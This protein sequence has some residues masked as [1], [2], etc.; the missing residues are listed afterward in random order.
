MNFIF[1]GYISVKFSNKQIVASLDI[2]KYKMV[3]S[4]NRSFVFGRT[5][6]FT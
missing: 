1:L 2:R 4:K 3:I 6:L 5:F